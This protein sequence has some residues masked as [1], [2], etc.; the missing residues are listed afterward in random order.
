[1]G[2]QEAVQRLEARMDAMANAVLSLCASFAKKEENSKVDRNLK[3]DLPEFDGVFNAE[4]YLDWEKAMDRYFDFKETPDEEKFK[5]AKLKLSKAAAEWLVGVQEQRVK[6]EKSK[7]KSWEK[8]KKKLRRKYVSKNYTQQLYVKWS[9]L[10]QGKRSVEDYI[11]EFEKLSIACKVDEN[12]DL[13]M[14][15]FIAGLNG[16]LREKV[17]VHQN[18]GFDEACKMAVVYEGHRRRKNTPE[19]YLKEAFGD[20]YKAKFDKGGATTSTSA[21]GGST[22]KEEFKAPKRDITC[23][24]CGGRGHT[25]AQCPNASAFTKEDW[26]DIRSTPTKK[27]LLVLEDDGKEVLCKTTDEGDL[28]PTK[29][30]EEDDSSSDSDKGV[31]CYGEKLGMVVRLSLQNRK[32]SEHEQRQSLFQ[33]RGVVKGELCD[34]IVDSGSEADCVAK[35]FVERLGLTTIKHPFPYRLRW[36]EDSNQTTVRRQCMVKFKVGEYEDERLC[37]VVPIDACQILLGRPWQSDRDTKHWGKENSYS[38]KHQGKRF[39]LLPLAPYDRK[40]MNGK[41]VSEEMVQAITARAY[42]QQQVHEANAQHRALVLKQGTYKIGDLVFVDPMKG[43]YSPKMVSKRNLL[44]TGSENGPF[45]IVEKPNFGWVKLELNKE[46]RILANF[47]VEDCL[48]YVDDDL[49]NLRAN[50]FSTGRVCTMLEGASEQEV[51]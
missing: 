8:L 2:E 51:A 21:S 13:K 14:G 35:D 30:G 43:K 4:M 36:L 18:I 26:M 20:N 23:F 7:I 45:S 50:S 5:I 22:T 19:S 17:E 44:F 12:D 41:N 47:R 6:E 3:I 48:P 46:P 32:E 11:Q 27:T 38:V 29:G 40:P 9:G 37:D 39:L 24:K 49:M 16:D 31:P 10:Q 42:A 28:M 1:M 15:R 33:T 34:V 25:R